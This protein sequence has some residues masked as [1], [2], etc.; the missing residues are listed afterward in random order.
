MNLLFVID[1]LGSG[2]AQRQMVNLAVGLNAHGHR[3]DFYVYYP[4]HRH[5]ASQ[6]QDSGLKVHGFKKQGRYDWR[7]VSHLR[8]LMR[9]GEYDL[10]LAFLATPAFYL[11]LAA[12]GTK[13]P[14]VVSERSVYVAQKLG[15]R[16]WF[17][18]QLH[19]LSNHITVNSHHQFKNMAHMFPWMRPKLSVIY[20]GIDLNIFYP[21]H[22]HTT[23]MRRNK[24]FRFLAI[25][26]VLPNKN[27]FALAQAFV[28]LMSLQP[29][30]VDQIAISWAGKIT[31]DF[32]SQREF[33]RTNALLQEEGLQESWYWL[34]ER[35]DVPELLRSAD[36]LIHPAFYEG[37]PNAI[38]EALASG[39]PV[40]ASNIG[41]HPRLIE[42]GKTGFL[43]SAQD[44][45]SISHAI[46]KFCNLSKAVRKQ[47][48]MNARCSAEEALSMEQFVLAYE[49]LFTQ[50]ISRAC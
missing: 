47:M 46:C 39:L 48:S 28:N 1:S 15:I 7:P 24:P 5:F 10:A 25:G 34:G 38:C 3:V 16:S 12:L 20:N 4:Q 42:D 44:P 13:I 27:P 26:S 6:L 36:A 37:L 14:V 22:R 18:Q 2:G 41:D 23:V 21:D 40:L 8:Q 33:A 17:L 11:E 30:L 35:S 31:D 19:R 32:M 50:L 43:F 9:I 45:E 49:N 29:E